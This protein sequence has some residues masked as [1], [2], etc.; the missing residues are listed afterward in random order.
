MHFGLFVFWSVVAFTSCLIET[1]NKATRLTKGRE[2]SVPDIWSRRISPNTKIIYSWYFE[3]VLEF[4]FSKRDQSF[5]IGGILQRLNTR[6]E[7]HCLRRLTES[8]RAELPAALQS[9]TLWH[10]LSGAT[11]S[12]IF[13]C[14]ISIWLSL[15][16]VLFHEI[17]PL[18]QRSLNFKKFINVYE[19]TQKMP[20]PILSWSLV[21]TYPNILP[22]L[23]DSPFYPFINSSP[24]CYI[25]LQISVAFICSTF[26]LTLYPFFNVKQRS[27]LH[28]K[29]C[30]YFSIT[31]HVFMEYWASYSI[32]AFTNWFCLTLLLAKR[33]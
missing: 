25:S 13:K 22:V 21:S 20:F 7:A 19:G 14:P 6:G 4:W 16:Y 9:P 17:T 27:C 29:I 10:Q 32:R 12:G 31:P 18:S 3:F 30:L 33:H 28:S 23:L 15:L 11:E 26:S 5:K 2:S 1:I 24:S 8:C